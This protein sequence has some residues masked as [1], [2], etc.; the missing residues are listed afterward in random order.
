MTSSRSRRLPPL[1]RAV[2]VSAALFLAVIVAA[3]G[4]ADRPASTEPAEPA[5]EWSCPGFSA[6]L[7][8]VFEMPVGADDSEAM[9]DVADRAEALIPGAPPDFVAP[10]TRIAADPHGTL[11]EVEILAADQAGNCR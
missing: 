5:G 3:C 6:L 2:S 4:S 8:A 7:D 1:A 11:S 9:R 10:L